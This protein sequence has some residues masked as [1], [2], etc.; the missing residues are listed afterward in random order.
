MSTYL[1][2]TPPISLSGPTERDIEMTRSLEEELRAHNVF[3]STEEA[4]L[5]YV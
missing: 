3:E 5:R 1:G 2:V 4:K